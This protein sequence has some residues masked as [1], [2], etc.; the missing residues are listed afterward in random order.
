M[1]VQE[2]EIGLVGGHSVF[3]GKTF[4]VLASWFDTEEQKGDIFVGVQW[5]YII[6]V[7]D[8]KP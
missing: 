7:K 3:L 8:L 2:V 4:L 1:G 5:Y 6:A